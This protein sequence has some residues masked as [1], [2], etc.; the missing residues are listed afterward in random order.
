MSEMPHQNSNWSNKSTFMDDF[1]GHERF[2]CDFDSK[3]TTPSNN[4]RCIGRWCLR[5]AILCPISCGHICAMFTPRHTKHSKSKNMKITNHGRRNRRSRHD[6]AIRFGTNTMSHVF[7]H[8]V[9][10]M[11]WKNRTLPIKCMTRAE[12]GL[13]RCAKHKCRLSNDAHVNSTLTCWFLGLHEMS[14]YIQFAKFVL[15]ATRYT[16]TTPLANNST[17]RICFTNVNGCLVICFV[18]MSWTIF[19]SNN[20]SS[21]RG[22]YLDDQVAY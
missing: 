18:S 12:Y 8:L 2:K 15:W 14:L 13:P 20:V 22:S 3:H 9:S 5:L 10:E 17:I 11:H 21:L 7:L 19:S 6:N 16:T 1:T 4:T